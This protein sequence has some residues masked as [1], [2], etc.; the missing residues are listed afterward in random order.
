MYSMRLLAELAFVGVFVQAAVCFA[1]TAPTVQVVQ[2]GESAAKPDDCRGIIVGPGVNQPDAFPGY[3]GFV[4]WESP[5]RLQN[6][7]WLVGFNAGY[8]HAS[9]PTPLRYPPKSLDA[10]RKMGMPDGVTAPTGGRVMITRSKDKGRTW[11]KPQ[12][13]IDTPADDRHPAFLQL[14]DGTLLCTFF[15]YPG[16]AENDDYNK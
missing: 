9:A 10:F 14:Q 13:L 1:A 3:G 5:I 8:W 6:G 12:T 4:G 2:N 15:T 7:D 11:S 16:Q